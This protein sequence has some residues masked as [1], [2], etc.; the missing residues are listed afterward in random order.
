MRRFTTFLTLKRVFLALMVI[1]PGF[2]LGA[3]RSTPAPIPQQ[4]P[5]DFRL[6]VVVMTDEDPDSDSKDLKGG[7]ARYIIDSSSVLRASFGSG[8]SLEVFPG[9]TRRLSI[10]QMDA[11]WMM[12]RDLLDHNE[13]LVEMHA[14]QPQ[15]MVE[16]TSGTIIEVHMNAGDQVYVFEPSDQQAAAIVD[17]LAALAWVDT[18]SKTNP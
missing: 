9:F 2:M 6:G 12:T 14:G 4:R 13:H 7:D 18:S 11:I 16:R 17:A 1:G 5:G 3:C 10:D 15:S 8:S